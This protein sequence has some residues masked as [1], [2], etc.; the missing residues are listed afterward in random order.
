MTTPTIA[1][2][3]NPPE[4]FLLNI[5]CEVPV[6]VKVVSFNDLSLIVKAN[7]VATV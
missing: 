4:P 1:P 2:Q 7:W 5:L 3:F 6:V